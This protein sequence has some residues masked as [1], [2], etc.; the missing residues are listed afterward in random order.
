MSVENISGLGWPASD[1]LAELVAATRAYK[2]KLDN[3]WLCA[4]LGDETD[5]NEYNQVS[6]RIEALRK[7]THAL[8]AT[9]NAAD[10][11]TQDVR[12]PSQRTKVSKGNATV[13][14]VIL[15][16]ES[17]EHPDAADTFVE[18]LQ[19]FGLERVRALGLKLS[20]IALV[21][22]ARGEYQ[23]QKPKGGFQICTHSNT[24]DKKKLL[25]KIADELH[26]PIRV[27]ILP[28]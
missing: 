15:N 1:N 23:S 28:K 6:G 14:R 25:E 27:E 10:V 19:R 2:S 24:A 3:Y 22:I 16:G 4:L 5:F 20:G 12:G 26:L 7:E 21:G 8:L 9:F 17:I 13:L 18:C 11:P